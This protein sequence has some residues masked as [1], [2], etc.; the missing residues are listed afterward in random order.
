MV[1]VSIRGGLGNQ[2]LE[3]LC[4]YFDHKQIDNIN[5]G[6]GSTSLDWVK[7]VWINKVLVLDSKVNAV[8]NV[9]KYTLWK[10][11]NNFKKF[12]KESMR[13]I[14]LTRSVKPTDEIIIHVRGSD[15]RFASLFDFGVMTNHVA[16]KNP[17]KRILF[18]GDDQKFINRLIEVVNLGDY[19]VNVSKDP[20]TDWFRIIA[21]EQLYGA[22]SSFTL[23]A[24]LF[25]PNKKYLVLDQKSNNGP[26]KL[27]SFYYDCVQELFKGFFANAHWF[28]IMNRQ[29]SRERL[30]S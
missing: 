9:K 19:A 15:R 1:D 30:A 17:G 20:V 8:D 3:Y 29:L 22:F 10:D 16:D 4:A 25:D 18:I 11:K 28:S 21:C 5:V 2:V 13:P 12:T 26:V 23:S 27:D 14:L 6:V 24:M 7:K